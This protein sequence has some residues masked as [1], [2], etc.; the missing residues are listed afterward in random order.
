MLQMLGKGLNLTEIHNIQ[1]LFE[2]WTQMT[3]GPS[4]QDGTHMALNMNLLMQCKEPFLYN[5]FLPP[6]LENIV[7]MFM[8]FIKC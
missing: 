1:F 7:K 8:A 2:N 5:P 3:L 4:E 6:S